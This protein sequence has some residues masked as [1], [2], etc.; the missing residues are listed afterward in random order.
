[1]QSTEAAFRS[2]LDGLYDLP[3]VGNVRGRRLLLRDRARQGQGDTPVLRRRRVRAAAAR[4]P[5]RRA[6]RGRADLPGRRPRRP[7]GAAVAAAHLRPGGDRLHRLHAARGAD[8]GV[9]PAVAPEAA[10][11]Y[12][13]LSLWW[14]AIPV[15]LP[16]RPALTED[17][18]VDVCIVGAGFTGLWTA[19]SLALADPSLRIAVLEREVAGF[20]ASG[21]NGGWCSALFATSDAALAR[22]HGLDAMRA[23]RRAMQETVDV[24][25]AARGER[26]HRLP[27][28]QGWLGRPGAQRG[29]AGP[30]AG[31]GRRGAGARVRRGRPALARARRDAPADRRGRRARRDVHAALRR[32]AAGAPGPRAGRRRRAARRARSTS[33]PRCSP[34]TPARR[35]TDRRSSPAGGTVRAEVVVRA[36]EAWTPTLPGLRARHRPGVLPHGGH[37]AARRGLLGRG[38]AGGP[39][40]LRRPPPHDHLRAAHGRRPHRLRGPGGAVPLRLDR[41]PRLRQRAGGA[42]PA[43]PDPGRALPGAGRRPLHPRLGRAAR[44]PAGLALLGRARPRHRPG[45]GRRVRGRRGVHHQPGRAHAGRPHHRGRHAADPAA[46]GRAPLPALG[47]RAAALARRQRRAVDHEAGRPQRGPAR[48][49]RAGWPEPWGA[50]SASD[51]CHNRV[52][53]GD[54]DRGDHQADLHLRRAD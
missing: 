37:R 33:T 1:M 42:R 10:S 20:G 35:A 27:L 54:A 3:I 53:A 15:P 46:L 11:G 47:A 5:V 9:A 44:H 23:M 40:H 36:T 43:A 13:R 41:P 25:G 49:A 17:L 24:V 32:G 12:Q 30:G 28:R 18:D 19:H 45:L 16:P 48:A 6:V 2:A 26:G 51:R 22:Q 39:G 29:P 31:R 4:L 7:G 8:R 38:R 52:R 21:R 14:E 34:S 50:S